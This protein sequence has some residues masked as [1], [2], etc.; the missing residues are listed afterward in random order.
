MSAEATPSTLEGPVRVLHFT[1]TLGGGGVERL[2]W[3]T[4]RLSD[5]GR[6]THR[7]VTYFPDGYFGP[8]VF[9]DRLR[10]AGAYEDQRVV[11]VQ[12]ET[13]DTPSRAVKVG[14]KLPSG[15]KR[16]LVP[17]V[18]LLAGNYS[19]ASLR[20]SATRRILSEFV[21]FRPHVVHLHGFYPFGYV[22]LFRRMLRTPVVHSVPAKFSQM[23]D[24][25]TGWLPMQYE[26]FHRFVDRFYVIDAY[27]HELLGVGVPNEK[28]VRLRGGVSISDITSVRAEKERQR[29]E[30][31]SRLG[32]PDDSLIALSVGRLDPSKGHEFSLEALPTLLRQL[33]NLHWVVLGEGQTR[34]GLTAR[35]EELGLKK[36]VHLVG[37]VEDTLPFYVAADVFLRT[38]IFEGDNLSSCTAAAAG[39]PVVGFDTQCDSDLIPRVGHGF[40]VPNRDVAALANATIKILTLPDRGVSLAQAAI[41]YCRDQMDIQTDI[42]NFSST[43]EELSQVNRRIRHSSVARNS[44]AI[45]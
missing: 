45:S 23:V 35:I 39:L 2:V 34:E 29:T 42:V 16:N 11:T 3:D 43:Y 33:P 38:T 19:R 26:Q 15:L 41:D 22:K 21:S 10:R 8:F 6:I 28:I 27:R 37:Y 24:Q 17:A 20:F 31:R 14:R 25:G 32:I 4:V 5:P 36:N 7:V 13:V 30:V 18:N 9:A 44:N 1:D 12:S 40:V